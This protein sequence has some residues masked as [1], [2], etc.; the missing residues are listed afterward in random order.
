MVGCG[1]SVDGRW[2]CGNGCGG[3]GE[4]LNRDMCNCRNIK[5]WS[6]IYLEKEARQNK[7][8][9]GEKIR[10]KARL[11]DERLEEAM[12]SKTRRRKT[13]QG[14]A[15]QK[16][17]RKY[18]LGEAKRGTARCHKT[19]RGEKKNDVNECLNKFS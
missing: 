17:S 6:L 14:N 1:G 16:Y 12:R 4:Y 8:R 19:I 13:G 10:G 18:E 15:R 7:T 9:K 3:I 11:D 2:F 5:K